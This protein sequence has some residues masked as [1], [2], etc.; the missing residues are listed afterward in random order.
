MPK[1]LSCRD[2]L[3]WIHDQQFGHEILSVSVKIG[4]R[5]NPV[6]RH[7]GPLWKG[8]LKVFAFTV[9]LRPLLRVEVVRSAENLENVHNL[10]NLRVS[11][12]ERGRGIEHFAQNTADGPDV[13]RRVVLSL[14]QQYLRRSVPQSD[15]LVAQRGLTR[16]RNL[17]SSAQPEVANLDRVR[18]LNDQNVLWLEVAVDDP[19]RMATGNTL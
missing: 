4:S 18:V 11:A 15:H 1:C 13:D 10:T 17:H 19:Q 6:H 5:T 2:S 9:N 14:S 12:K 3:L 16:S 7:R 8:T